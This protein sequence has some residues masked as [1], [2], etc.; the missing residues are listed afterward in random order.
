MPG[1]SAKSARHLSLKPITEIA[2]L[3][4]TD[5]GLPGNMTLA[6]TMTNAMAQV[7]VGVTFDPAMTLKDKAV[8]VARELDIDITRRDSVR[9]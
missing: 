7:F 1:A 2:A 9:T 5:L 8:C 6:E 4:Q 3:I